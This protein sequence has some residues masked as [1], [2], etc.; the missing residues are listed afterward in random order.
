M[1]QLILARCGS[2]DFDEQDRIVGNLDIPVDVR[3]QAEMAELARDLKD[4]PIH[5]IYSSAGE[6]A[7]ESARF[8]GEKLGVRV[9]VLEDLRNVDFGL[10]QGLPISEVRRK[11]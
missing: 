8:L 5:T 1:G 6:S 3:G 10:W 7:R 2:T 9:K 11:H 4:T